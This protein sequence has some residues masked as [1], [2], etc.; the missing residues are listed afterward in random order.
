MDM[1]EHPQSPFW[2]SA[3]GLAALAFGAVA[4]FF[5]FTE[6][7]AHLYGILPWVLLLCCP[8]MMLFMHHGHNGHEG[9]D[10]AVGNP[11]SSKHTEEKRP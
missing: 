8:V 11:E 1:H 3:A 2:R 7:Q 9:H 5:L 4:A 10:H 6:H